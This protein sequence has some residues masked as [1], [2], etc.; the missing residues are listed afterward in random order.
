MHNLFKRNA[1]CLLACLWLLI[2]ITHA[3]AKE[4]GRAS[5][6]FQSG[7]MV[8]EV[9]DAYAFLGKP[10]LGG[11]EKVIIVV[12]SNQGFVKAA[13]D[14]YWDRKTSL[15]RYF[16]DEKTGLVYLEF[17]TDGRY[18][19]LSYYF[20]SGNGC[21]YCA[22]S[23]VKSTVRL[24]DNKMTGNLS[25]PEGKDPNRWFEISIDVPVSNDDHGKA[26]GP[27]GGEPGKA[28]LAYH[29]AL[30]GKDQRAIMALLSEERRSAWTK[31]EGQGRGAA[32]LEFLR[33]E[34]PR[35]VRVTAAYVKGDKALLLLEGKGEAGKVIGEAQFSKEK[36][37]WRFDEET[38]GPAAE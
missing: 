9:K 30:A 18:R 38:L 13:L 20:G 25:F 24:K 17:S 5:G 3:A 31:A 37:A 29:R 34:H 35:D 12:V 8:M 23:S 19:G 21:G 11:K 6:T 22:D 2:A 32:F 14:E 16:K 10:S 7:E 26:Q 28:Y 27:G 1:I 4:G 36:S 33:A 15:E